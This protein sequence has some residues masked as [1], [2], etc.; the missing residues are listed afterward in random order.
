MW[1]V[2]FNPVSL[3]VVENLVMSKLRSHG[4]N[5]NFHFLIFIKYVTH[6]SLD[7]VVGLNFLICTPMC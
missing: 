7:S 2:S 6:K 4:S 3:I 5:S 1:T